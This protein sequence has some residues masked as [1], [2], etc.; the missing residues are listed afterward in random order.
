M[1]DVEIN[2]ADHKYI[3]RIIHTYGQHDKD[4]MNIC[5]Q[6]KSFLI[7]S[8]FIFVIILLVSFILLPFINFPV[9][10][11]YWYTADVLLDPNSY[12][13]ASGFM[14]YGLI[15]IILFIIIFKKWIWPTSRKCWR[16]ITGKNR[17]Q[18]S[19]PRILVMMW[20]SFRNKYCF[21]VKWNKGEK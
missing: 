1:N 8:F 17:Q 6:I 21:N 4:E 20:N 11:Y 10:V 3:H 5:E 2:I 9:F 18:S 13:E 7:G 15:F 12:L 14:E 16:I 19:E